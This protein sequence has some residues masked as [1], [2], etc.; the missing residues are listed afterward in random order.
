MV[1]VAPSDPAAREG[2]TF[3]PKE[4]Q[5]GLSAVRWARRRFNIDENR[6][7]ASGFSRGG[8]MVWDLTLRNPDLFAAIAPMIGGPWTVVAG[9]RNNLRYL[10]T[11][12]SLP[13][14]DLQGSKDD[15]KL[16]ADLRYCFKRLKGF[17]AKNA[18]LIEFPELGHAFEFGKV[19]W[20][21]F[22]TARRNPLPKTALAMTA[23][24]P[25]AGHT[26]GR[27]YFAEI[28]GVKSNIVEDVKMKVTKQKWDSMDDD[29]RRRWM[30][31]EAEKATAR[32]EATWTA[33]GQFSVKSSGVT[34]ARLLCVAEMVDPKQP[35][36]VNANG[37]T[38]KHPVKLD[39][40]V[41]LA[42]FAERFDR[43]FLP[44]AEIKLESP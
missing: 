25:P 3:T 30:N 5:A 14:R 34:K 39:A 17:G 27:A 44:V 38:L 35:A 33:P 11:L 43:T 2:Y 31:E 9:D 24:R 8:H 41:L 12:T 26:S 6:I 18:E 19:K 37:K 22:L 28:L 4:R 21:E 7:Y 20:T 42:E 29:A 32:L 40:A 10:E 1:V 36:S 13:I 23:G 15:P 16:I